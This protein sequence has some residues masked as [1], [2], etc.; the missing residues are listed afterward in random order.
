MVGKDNFGAHHF[1]RSILTNESQISDNLES[2]KSTQRRVN[3]FWPEVIYEITQ[4]WSAP[5]VN[6][7]GLERKIS[8]EPSSWCCS[9]SKKN[10]V[11]LARSPFS[12]NV[13]L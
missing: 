13:L 7:Q 8:G 1:T 2:H 4:K 10:N 12:K 9:G 5:S 6:I 11:D 3:H